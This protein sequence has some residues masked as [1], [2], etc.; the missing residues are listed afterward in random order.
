M[1]S[2]DKKQYIFVQSSGRILNLY[3]DSRL[4]LCLS[5]L[6]KRSTWTE[7]IPVQKNAYN[8][9]FADIDTEDRIHIIF[10]DRQ[11]NISYSCINN[12]SVSTIPI[13]NS[14]SVSSYNKHFFLIPFK[15]NIHLFYVLRHDGSNLLAHQVLEGSKAG[16]P[17]VIDYVAE[18]DFPYCAIL[19]KSNSMYV[20]YQSFDGK[21]L[22]LGCKKYNFS[23]NFW[24]DFSAITR[25][26]G[27]SEYPRAI[28]DKDGVI[29]ICYQ[30]C[31]EKQ[32]ELVYQQKIPDR[33]LWTSE[34]VIHT[35]AYNF[36]D[37]SILCMDDS[38][39]IYWVRDDIIYYSSS[40]DSGIT[41]SK[42]SKYNFI[43]GRQ[44]M[45]M[46]YSSNSLYDN[47]KTSIKEIPGAF[48]NGIKLA[49]YQQA[50]QTSGLAPHELKDMIVDSLKALKNNAE[51]LRDNDK[52]LQQDISKVELTLQKLEREFIKY[53][54]KLDL[55]QGDVNQ[56]KLAVNRFE[57]FKNTINEK[58]SKHL[59]AQPE[60]ANIVSDTKEDI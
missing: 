51:E 46:Q 58:E 37:S 50:A 35:S 9:F 13:L 55:L 12:N 44:L 27:N 59:E 49:F 5:V 54:V 8:Y 10:Q 60:E 52:I 25:F 43:A 53:T 26:D 7:P 41:W 22:Q 14:K 6:T 2:S 40:K 56:L 31:F 28:T 18:G 11:G 36:R 45:C 57:A 16:S 38:I 19:D 1:Y 39:I 17:R 21:Y 47:A 4:G 23:Q 42:P 33:S 15:N 34:V 30:R 20:F 24:G 48:I 3:Y 32:L 29:H